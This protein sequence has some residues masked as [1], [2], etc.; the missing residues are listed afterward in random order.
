MTMN[1]AIILLGIII[2]IYT[3]KRMGQKSKRQQKR[4]DEKFEEWKMKTHTWGSRQR[5]RRRK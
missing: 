5:G 4:E 3:F 1:D 2:L